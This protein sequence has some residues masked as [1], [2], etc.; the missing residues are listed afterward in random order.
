MCLFVCSEENSSEILTENVPEK[1]LTKHATMI[2]NRNLKCRE[3]WF[4]LVEAIEEPDKSINHVQW[5]DVKI[6]ITDKNRRSKMT[7]TVHDE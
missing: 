6:W 7:C 3:D 2:H 4:K 5:E 1:L